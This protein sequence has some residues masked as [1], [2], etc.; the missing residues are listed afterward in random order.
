MIASSSQVADSNAHLASLAQVEQQKQGKQ[1]ESSLIRLDQVDP[2]PIKWLWANYIPLGKVVVLQGDPGAGKSTLLADLAARVTQGAPMPDGSETVKGSVLIWTLEDDLA[3]TLRPRLEAANANLELVTGLD[4]SIEQPKDIR[5][6]VGNA[7]SDHKKQTT[8]QLRLLIID[9]LSTATGSKDLNKQN[10]ARP[11]MESLTIIARKEKLCIVVVN[12]LNKSSPDLQSDLQR[13]SGSLGGIA[14]VARTVLHAQ[15]PF[16]EE[17]G[18][19]HL[20]KS[21]VAGRRPPLF[22]QLETREIIHANN[23]HLKTGAAVWVDAPEG[24]LC[25]AAFGHTSA[26]EE[27]GQWLTE[28]LKDGPMPFAEVEARADEA[29]LSMSGAVTRAK[30]RLG[31]RS[32]KIGQQWMWSLPEATPNTSDNDVSRS[33]ELTNCSAN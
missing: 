32:T 5:N 33:A 3:D 24:T 18:A 14:G 22:Y 27:G 30:R 13:G 29:R 17:T 28:L 11:I 16:E 20:I 6:T 9:P 10:N 1:Q 26:I 21:N 31:V 7:M 25:P 23:V 19:L 8:E 4:Q 15:K 12:H 2:K